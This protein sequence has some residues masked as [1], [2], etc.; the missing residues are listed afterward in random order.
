M[1]L[2]GDGGILLE[3]FPET[4]HELNKL[5]FGI[6]SSIWYF[7]LW[8]K[9]LL[10]GLIWY[11]V[12]LLFCGCNPEIGCLGWQTSC[13]PVVSLIFLTMH[14]LTWLLQKWWPTRIVFDFSTKI[15]WILFLYF[16]IH[17]SAIINKQHLWKPKRCGANKSQWNWTKITVCYWSTPWRNESCQ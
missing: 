2:I 7:G 9:V 3:T 1:R 17:K 13:F 15:Y 5:Q 4:T 10:C 8:K 12:L 11:I 14:H 16:Y 6:L